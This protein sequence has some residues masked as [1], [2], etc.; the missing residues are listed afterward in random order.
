LLHVP[1]WPD[2]KARFLAPTEIVG[3]S[4]FNQTTLWKTVKSPAV[5]AWHPMTRCKANYLFA[6][7]YNFSAR[8][9]RAAPD[10]AKAIR[11][12]A[13]GRLAV[14]WVVGLVSLAQV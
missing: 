5:N 9:S 2:Q 6:P 8:N 1:L 3:A 12:W 7:A 14:N 11:T 13:I 10:S 4:L